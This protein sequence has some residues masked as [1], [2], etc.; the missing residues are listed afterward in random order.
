M[1]HRKAHDI[2][3]QRIPL[4]LETIVIKRRIDTAIQDG[5][6]Q[7]NAYPIRPAGLPFQPQVRRETET[8]AL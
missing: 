5:Q 2:P 6:P 4:Q 3:S 7:A 1:G 8:P